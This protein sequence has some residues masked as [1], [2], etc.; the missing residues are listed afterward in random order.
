MTTTNGSS[1]RP[2]ATRTRKKTPEQWCDLIVAR[3]S[4]LRAA[5]V[6]QLELDGAT[7]VLAP[8][9]P[10]EPD[11]PYDADPPRPDP[12]DPFDDPHTY[13]LGGRVPAFPHDERTDDE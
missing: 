7:F 4:A 1:A 9:A 13:G 8:P 5:G 3:A 11:Y 12:A 2:R 6:L 10:I